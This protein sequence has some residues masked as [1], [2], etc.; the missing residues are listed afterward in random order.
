M[1]ASW[2]SST[3]LSRC[4]QYPI[5]LSF[6]YSKQRESES[7]T[8]RMSTVDYIHVCDSTWEL[9]LFSSIDLGLTHCSQRL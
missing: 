4:E 1:H 6:W 9:R 5:D 3:I 7:D 8:V 2:P